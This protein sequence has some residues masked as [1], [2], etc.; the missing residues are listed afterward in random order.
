MSDGPPV[1]LVEDEAQMRRFLRAA[2]TSRGY[3]LVEAEKGGEAV[4]LGER[5]ARSTQNYLIAQGI[6]AGRISIISYGEERPLCTD[7]T[8]ACWAKNRRAHLVVKPR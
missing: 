4:P 1:L 8:E 6:A 5:R 3:R 2:L 7:K